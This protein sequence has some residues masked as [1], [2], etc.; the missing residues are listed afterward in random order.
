VE[1]RRGR[2]RDEEGD[3]DGEDRPRPDVNARQSVVLFGHALLDHRRLDED[4]HV[5][6][7]GRADERDDREEVAGGEVGA[8]PREAARHLAP[9]GA[10]Q[11]G[12][13]DVAEEDE[14]HH[15]EDALDAAVGAFDDQPPDG[16][17]RQRHRD[18][19]RDAEQLGR[20]R[21]ADELRDGHAAVGDEERQHHQHRP[22]HAELLADEVGEPLARHRPHPRARLLHDAERQDQRDESPEEVVAVVGPGRGVGGDAARVVTRVGGNHPGPDDGEVGQQAAPRR[23]RALHAPRPAPPQAATR[24]P[25][26]LCARQGHSEV[27]RQR[28]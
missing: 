27:P 26:S 3:G 24:V 23:G 25:H 18:E 28:S 4:L 8:R 10:R 5:G 20:R 13:D 12:R 11:E 1:R 6:R 9:V 2:H 7:D 21:D 14:R 22:A 17:G 19:A 15:E 16:E